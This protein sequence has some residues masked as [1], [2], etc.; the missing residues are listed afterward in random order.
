MGLGFWIQAPMVT[1][2]AFPGKLPASSPIRWGDAC[3][4]PSLHV[5]MTSGMSEAGESGG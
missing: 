2:Y 5:V 4:L 1:S 3:A